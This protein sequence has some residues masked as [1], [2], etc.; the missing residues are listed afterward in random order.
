MSKDGGLT[1]SKITSHP[2]LIE[3]VWQA[4]LIRYTESLPFMKNRPAFF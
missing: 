3:P 2:T 1:W 4:S